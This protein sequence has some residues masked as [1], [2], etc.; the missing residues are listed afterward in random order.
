MRKEIVNRCQVQPVAD[1]AVKD[2]FLR[3]HTITAPVLL[4]ALATGSWK[5][6][7]GTSHHPAKIVRIVPGN[8]APGKGEKINQ[9]TQANVTV[10]FY[11]FPAGV[12][13]K[14]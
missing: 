6:F 14:E 8:N 7:T 4:L 11:T 9:D 1:V 10:H 13:K 12:Y 2:I 5:H 3:L